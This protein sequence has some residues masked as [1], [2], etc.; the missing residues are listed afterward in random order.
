MSAQDA[1][2]NLGQADEDALF[3]IHQEKVHC[4][5][6]FLRR[7]DLRDAGKRPMPNWTGYFLSMILSIGLLLGKGCM[8]DASRYSS[9]AFYRLAVTRHLSHVFA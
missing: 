3:D 8:V 1:S 7:N 2:S 6:P 5:F 9:Q 4:K